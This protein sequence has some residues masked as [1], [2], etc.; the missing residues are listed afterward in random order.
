MSTKVVFGGRVKHG[1][2]DFHPVVVYE[3]EDPDAAN[4]FITAGWASD[5]GDVPT[6][7]LVSAAEVE[8]DPATVWGSGENKGSPVLDGPA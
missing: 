6:D 5:A 2:V 4:Y 7:V 1:R 3:F 8:I